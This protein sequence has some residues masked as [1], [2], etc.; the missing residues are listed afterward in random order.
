MATKKLE[1][2]EK[3]AAL[4]LVSSGDLLGDGF[5]SV[6]AEAYGAI[7]TEDGVLIPIMNCMYFSVQRDTVRKI[8]TVRVQTAT[9]SF[10][11]ITCASADDAEQVLDELIATVYGV[12][13]TP[14]VPEV[15]NLAHPA[16]I[17]PPVAAEKVDNTVYTDRLPE[18]YRPG[19]VP[20]YPTP[21]K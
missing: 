6:Y 12:V 21:A 11:V 18:G 16:R 8:A 9:D 3:V 20:V 17:L 10:A 1:T 14:T 5:E 2:D 19:T 7:K 4:T 13:Y 15:P